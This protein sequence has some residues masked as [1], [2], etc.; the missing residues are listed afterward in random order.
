MIG[1]SLY[2]CVKDLAELQNQKVEVLIG[3]RWI[4]SEKGFFL[5][6]EKRMLTIENVEKIVTE[7]AASTDEE[8][9]NL[10]GVYAAKYWNNHPLCL[11]WA[12]LLWITGKIEQP[13][14]KGK[15][16]YSHY[17]HYAHWVDQESLIRGPVPLLVEDI[18]TLF[19]SKIAKGTEKRVLR[20]I[21]TKN[22]WKR[23]EA[24]LFVDQIAR[25][26]TRNPGGVQL[27]L[28]RYKQYMLWGGLATVFGVIFLFGSGNLVHGGTFAL[29]GGIGFV[30]G[31]FGWLIYRGRLKSNQPMA[32]EA[33]NFRPTKGNLILQPVR[34]T[35]TAVI[36]G[37]GFFMLSVAVFLLLFF[38][39]GR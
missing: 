33:I 3:F 4:D 7:T 14:L 38:M 15:E 37:G 9:E 34:T 27:I 23:D 8:W 39:G 36:I 30:W 2:Y 32:D 29:G 24:T 21:L 5:V 22:L 20:T 35:S 6:F 18:V 17:A 10:C 31:L 19:K 25:E 1:T 28:K 16:H 26:L 12:K 11:L 13:R